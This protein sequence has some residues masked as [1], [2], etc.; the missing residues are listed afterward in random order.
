MAIILCLVRSKQKTNFWYAGFIFSI[1]M[2]FL[3]EFIDPIPSTVVTSNI[4]PFT[5]I[6][7]LCSA[8]SY[9]FSTYFFLLIGLS[10][11]DLKPRQ[12]KRLYFI[13]SLPIII[14]FAY[15]LVF[16]DKGFIKIYLNYSPNFWIMS[17]WGIAC[18]VITNAL[19][20]YTFIIA[21]EYHER[22]L[23]F[24][25]FII[26]L[27]SLYLTYQAYVNPLIV[28]GRHDFA[29]ITGLVT[30]TI[31]L[32]AVIAAFKYGFLGIRLSIERETREN[33]LKLITSGTM[34]I[35]HSLKNEI[36]KIHYA[37][38]TLEK[39]TSDA[40]YLEIA[41]VIQNSTCHLQQ[42]IERMRDRTQEIILKKEK[43]NIC[44]IIDSTLDSIKTILDERKIEIFKQYNVH[45]VIDCDKVHMHEVLQNILKNAIEAL[46]GSGTGII[47]I[48][49]WSQKRV[50]KIEIHDNGVGISAENLP[51]IFDPF[52]STKRTESNFGLGLT[53]CYS[54]IQ[55]H[56]GRLNMVSE[57]GQGT[58][59]VI[60]LPL[61]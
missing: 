54:V 8:L 7:R 16:W 60:D 15:D 42:V 49:V 17:I 57:A 1:S 43:C 45:L 21:K 36:G 50:I 2:G 32:S 46:P 18:G 35:A 9:R 39:M 27:P 59:V 19:L 13:F 47:N 25:L 52:F 11:L 26:T 31:F 53:Y 10:V 41:N 12:R 30:C 3:A 24:L 34:L 56:N 48:K 37:A 6:A 51:H 20:F 23:K 55:K 44:D 28:E 61:K 29:Y 22:V 14:G 5:L 58:S 33:S 4:E 40:N 38:E